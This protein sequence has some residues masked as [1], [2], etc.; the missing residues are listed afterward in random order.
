MTS[1]KLLTR[2]R[3]KRIVAL[4][5]D[6]SRTDPVFFPVDWEPRPSLRWHVARVAG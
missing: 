2:L 3:L 5:F 6:A 1:I 4:V